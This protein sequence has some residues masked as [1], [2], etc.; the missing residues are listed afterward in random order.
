MP[1]T[2]F[3]TLRQPL[4]LLVALV[5]FTAACSQPEYG[6]KLPALPSGVQIPANLQNKLRYDAS[7]QSLLL[8][9]H[10]DCS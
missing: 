6:V 4:L 10:F 1:Y 7:S 5:C 2:H 9:D 8:K 3:I